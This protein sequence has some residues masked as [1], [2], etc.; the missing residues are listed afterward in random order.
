M[1]PD[2]EEFYAAK[3]QELCR[4]EKQR[5]AVPSNLSRG[6]KAWTAE[7][8]RQLKFMASYNTPIRVMAMRLQRQIPTIETKLRA[9]NLTEKPQ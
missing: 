9:L 6:G 3:M 2:L 8:V 7:D 5:S 1:T 4:A